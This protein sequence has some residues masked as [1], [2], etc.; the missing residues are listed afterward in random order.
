M[1]PKTIG[2]GARRNIVH[3]NKRNS[4]N[5]YGEQTVIKY[6][7]KLKEFHRLKAISV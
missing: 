7:L 4:L 3:T 6:Y 2:N 1:L 5:F